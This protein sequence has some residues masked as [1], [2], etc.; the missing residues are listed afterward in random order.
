M[1]ERL[2][3]DGEPQRLKPHLKK[4]CIGTAEAVPFPILAAKRVSIQPEST[5][6]LQGR[7]GT[8]KSGGVT[9]ERFLR[10]THP[11]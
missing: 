11:G 6:R 2:A 7:I 3:A 4:H 1:V 5:A 10:T 9:D 8:A